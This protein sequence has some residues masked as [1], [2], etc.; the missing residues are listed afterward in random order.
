LTMADTL[1]SL[2]LSLYR[3]HLRLAREVDAAPGLAALLSISSL[4]LPPGLAAPPVAS[5]VLAAAGTLKAALLAPRGGAWFTP[6]QGPSWTSSVRAGYRASCGDSP[7]VDLD[8]AFNV[9]REVARGRGIAEAAEGGVAAAGAVTASLDALCGSEVE[10]SPSISP[11]CV[12][13]EHPAAVLPGRSALLVYDVSRNVQEVHGNE[14]MTLRGLALNRPFPVSVS[15]VTRLSGLGALGELPLFHGGPT[16]GDLYVVHR[17]GEVPGAVAIDPAGEGAG[18]GCGL[19]LG[20]DVAAI[21]G[22]LES[23][24]ARGGEFKVVLGSTEVRL[25]GGEE[26]CALPDPARWLCVRGAGAIGAAMLPPQFATS[27]AWAA[28]RGLGMTEVV[29]GYNYG[30]FWH[31]NAVW[32]YLWRTGARGMGVEWEAL[33]AL[34]AS[35]PHLLRASGPLDLQLLATAPVA[36]AQAASAEEAEAGTRGAPQTAPSLIG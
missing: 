34:H 35:V 17:R 9:G 12:L 3:V 15:I 1:R 6:G 30:R 18:A 20:G 5:E 10:E 19:F 28:G 25:E 11:G 2:T 32:A 16:G 21:N 22:L 31:Q 14:E 26:E 13:L 23:G 33:S 36:Y 29:E 24:A 27:G 4:A 8:A 7:A